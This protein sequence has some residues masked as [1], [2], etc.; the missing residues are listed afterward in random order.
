MY[1]D[2]HG[3]DFFGR[4][5]YRCSQNVI[6]A[7]EKFA[8]R[9]ITD[10][11]FVP[12]PAGVGNDRVFKMGV[13]QKFAQIFFRED[14]DLTGKRCRDPKNSYVTGFFGNR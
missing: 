12:S 8:P 5:E 10:R 6:A 13:T 2:M 1:K 7:S 11:I 9:V 14:K 4:P 3:A